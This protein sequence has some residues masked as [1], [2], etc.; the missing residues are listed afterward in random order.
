VDVRVVP[1][2][3]GYGAHRIRERERAREVVEAVLLLEV[4]PV[5]NVPTAAE[6]GRQ[7][8]ELLAPQGRHAAA[9][10]DAVLAG[11]LR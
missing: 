6:L 8:F 3:L 11:Q 4:V 9:T 5:D 10:R 2:G 1:F 7:L